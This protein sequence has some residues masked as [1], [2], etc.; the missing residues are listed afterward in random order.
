[1]T[2]EN[3]LQS[4][5]RSLRIGIV[6]ET[7]PPKINGVALT[8]A[9][10]V[11]GLR[12]RGHVVQLVRV[13]QGYGDAPEPADALDTLRLPGFRIPGY[14]QLQGGWLAQRTLLDHWQRTPLDLIHVVTE[15]PLGAAD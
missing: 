14:P 2:F 13:Q 8:I 4:R 12:Q 7:W 15:G 1:M 10:W 6:T 11:E 9:D 5:Q 3:A